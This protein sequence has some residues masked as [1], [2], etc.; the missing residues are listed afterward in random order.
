MVLCKTDAA[1]HS[2][3]ERVVGSGLE[4]GEWGSSSKCIVFLCFRCNI[5]KH[6]HFVSAHLPH[7]KTRGRYDD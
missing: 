4:L 6:I 7:Q 3:G 2:N 5:L 1:M